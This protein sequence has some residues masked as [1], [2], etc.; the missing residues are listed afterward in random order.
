MNMH[1][2]NYHVVLIKLTTDSRSIRSVM[3]YEAA[4]TA[5]NKKKKK[6]NGQDYKILK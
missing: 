2:F 1:S 6:K 4:L 3:L 5:I